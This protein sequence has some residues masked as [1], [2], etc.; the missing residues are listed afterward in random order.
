MES[1]STEELKKSEEL[2]VAREVIEKEKQDR[3]VMFNKELEALCEK[4]K[5]SISINPAHIVITAH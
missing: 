5:C 4:Y 2:K 3:A 1:V